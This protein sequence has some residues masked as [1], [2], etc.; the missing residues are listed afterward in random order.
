MERLCLDLRSGLMVNL[1]WCFVMRLLAPLLVLVLALVQGGVQ[2]AGIRSEGEQEATACSLPASY[3]ILSQC[4]TGAQR[5]LKVGV[6][7]VHAFL[8]PFSQLRLL[9]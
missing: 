1:V 3:S 2:A 9:G 5:H 6:A 4:D 7:V 8:V